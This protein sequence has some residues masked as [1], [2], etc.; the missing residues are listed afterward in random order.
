MK[1]QTYNKVVFNKDK[2][3]WFLA[4]AANEQ[5]RHLILFWLT[6]QKLY[7]HKERSRN[8]ITISTGPGRYSWSKATGSRSAGA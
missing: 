5:I 2:A 1:K 6:N 8:E 4:G 3:L 7:R